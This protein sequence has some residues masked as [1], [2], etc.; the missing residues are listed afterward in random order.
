M[1]IGIVSDTHGDQRAI[2]QVVAQVGPVDLWLH[3]GDHV[4]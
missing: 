3:A 1:R 4:R 2:K